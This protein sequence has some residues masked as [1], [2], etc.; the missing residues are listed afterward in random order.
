MGFQKMYGSQ[1]EDDI[2]SSYDFYE[3]E[4][5]EEEDEDWFNELLERRKKIFKQCSFVEN[6]I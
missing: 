5:C 4:E 2:P 6:K 3:D 1:C